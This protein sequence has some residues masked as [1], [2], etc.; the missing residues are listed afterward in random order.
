MGCVTVLGVQSPF[1][2]FCLLAVALGSMISSLT[3]PPPTCSHSVCVC[4]EVWGLRDY[5]RL[6]K[7]LEDMRGVKEMQIR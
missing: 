7:D 2:S 5:G 4:G 6:T 1:G 3:P